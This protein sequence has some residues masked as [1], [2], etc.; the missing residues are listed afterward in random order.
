MQRADCRYRMPAVRANALPSRCRCTAEPP[1][2]HQP[3]HMPLSKLPNKPIFMPM[4]KMPPQPQ[5]ACRPPSSALSSSFFARS[6]WACPLYSAAGSR[7]AGQL[8]CARDA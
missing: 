7:V 4:R 5:A 8:L 1:A 3:M 2:A 6:S